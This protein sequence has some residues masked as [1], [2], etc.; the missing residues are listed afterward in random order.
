ME[1]FGIALHIE[2]QGSGLA[3]RTGNLNQQVAIPIDTQYDAYLLMGENNE[4]R[5]I[6]SVKTHPTVTLK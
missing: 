3:G 4:N 6:G 5:L 2:N 1:C